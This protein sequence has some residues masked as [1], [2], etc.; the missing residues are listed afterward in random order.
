MEQEKKQKKGNVALVVIWK[1][2]FVREHIVGN[3]CLM[4]SKNQFYLNI[5]FFQFHI[6]NPK[7]VRNFLLSFSIILDNQIVHINLSKI[8]Q[9]K[10]KDTI[11]SH[12]NVQIL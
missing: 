10:Q 6:I 1:S 8:T 5:F 3:L 12:L 11:K 7:L 9:I 2:N 4:N